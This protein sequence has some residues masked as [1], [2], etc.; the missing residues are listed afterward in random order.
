MGQRK[1]RVWL[2]VLI[3]VATAAYPLAAF[4]GLRHHPVAPAIQMLLAVGF[5]ALAML[6]F[7]SASRPKDLS[8]EVL[9]RLRHVQH[10][11]FA[12]QF[13]MLRAQQHRKIKIPG[14]GRISLRSLGGTA[15][16]LVSGAWWM[17]PWAPVLAERPVIEDP[18]GRLGE[19]LTAVML[20]LFDDHVA[21]AQPPILPPDL[22]KLAGRVRDDAKPYQLGLRAM[23][24]G[25]FA[26]SRQRLGEAIEEENEK[27]KADKAPPP[28]PSIKP[29]LYVT[30]AQVEMYAG[31]FAEAAAAYDKAI[32]LSPSRPQLWCE[33]AAARI[34][35]GQFDLAKP[36]LDKAARLCR[37]NR[38]TTQREAAACEHLRS[39]VAV[40]RCK[41]FDDA[42]KQIED[43]RGNCKMAV[44]EDGLLVAANLN[45]QAVLYALRANYT[46]AQELLTLAQRIV[47]GAN[48][49]YDVHA[50]AIQASLAAILLTRAKYD[51]ARSLLE[52]AE[53]TLPATLPDD[54]PGRLAL[55]NLRAML[56]EALGRYDEAQKV[57]EQALVI[58]EKNLG[59]E[60]PAAAPIVDGL[61]VIQADRGRYALGYQ[62]S[63][64]AVTLVKKLWGPDHPFLATDLRHQAE[65]CILK[66][67]YTEGETVAQQAQ[68][69]CER[70]FG[71]RHPSLAGVLC[72]RARLAIL[73]DRMRDAR[74]PLG[75]ARDIWEGAYREHP[76]LAMVMGDLATL[77][78]SEAD[79]PEGVAQYQRAIDM[80]ER[81]VGPEHPKIARLLCGQA[82]LRVLQ[83]KYDEAAA[84]LERALTIQE[85]LQDAVLGKNHPDLAATLELYATVLTKTTP[86]N[87]ARAAEMTTRAKDILARHEEE[88]RVETAPAK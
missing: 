53:A 56:D 33:L 4:L 10:G 88:D 22:R 85:K 30:V 34:Q 57:A 82:A 84:C 43:A 52:N 72:T 37:D 50:L 17:S 59:V 41:D 49:Q 80:L 58:C 54:H 24:R 47:A 35:A 32:K 67:N 39:L 36:A 66:Q 16:L 9:E 28:D 75:R 6:T 26:E 65:L 11:D 62:S 86:P 45:N 61:A 13:R 87:A 23:V 31:R 2:T 21:V 27:E 70:S 79:L 48:G 15:V 38:D 1:N 46:G 3:G 7:L 68:A 77:D 64:R 40:A 20:V 5:V 71:K 51:E 78:R 73:Q 42:V 14:V 29:L 81:L 69:V 74:R 60:H 63:F 19:E 44:G 18:T 76:D 83:E 55:L 8:P 25:D 12:Q